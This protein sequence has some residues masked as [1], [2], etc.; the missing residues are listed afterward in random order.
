MKIA[1]II[2]AMFGSGGMERVISCKAN[3]LVDNFGYDVTVITYKQLGRPYH[4]PLSDS[5][6]CVNINLGSDKSKRLT[7]KYLKERL[8]E[9]LFAEKFDICI[10]TYGSEAYV[11]TK[12]ND[13]SKK[14]IEFH[15]A[16]PVKFNY[17]AI[18]HPGLLGKALA[19]I[20]TMRMVFTAL[21][22]DKIIVLTKSDLYRWK[23]YTKK[24]VQIYNPITIENT[25]ISDCSSKIAVAVGR[26]DP[27][28]GFDYL[29][30]SWN[31]VSKKHPDWIL[32]IYGAGDKKLYINRIR[33]L[34]LEDKVL[35]MGCSNDISRE[36]CSGALFVLSSRFEGFP[37][38]IVE[39][40]TK[41]LPI[42]SFNCPSGPSELVKNGGNGFLIPKVGDIQL[43]SDRICKLM[44]D[45]KMRKDMGQESSKRSLA[46]NVSSIM[47]QWRRL[48][49]EISV[50]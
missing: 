7:Y 30:D 23:R 14:M 41:G 2:E 20:K 44:E 39:A 33:Q 17:E 46:F 10:S 6:R 34:N 45:E 22:Y 27:Q 13:R 37:L 11:L 25:T 31:L 28:K 8:E 47:E 5:I 42:V 49:N 48:F 24:V 43:M 9:I 1:Y 35:F 40:M 29:I 32:K 26:L 12:I 4:Y 16:F 50:H 38:A 18:R 3:W 19:L 36:Y 21:S 15:F